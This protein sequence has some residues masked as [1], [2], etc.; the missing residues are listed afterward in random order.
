MKW[1][2]ASFVLFFAPSLSAVCSASW[3]VNTSTTIRLYDGPG[4]VGAGEFIVK[5]DQ[6][7]DKFKTERFRTFCVQLNEGVVLGKNLEIAG[8]SFQT[9]TSG[10]PLSARTSAL[11]RAFIDGYNSGVDKVSFFGEDYAK[12]FFNSNSN[13]SANLLQKAI[14]KYQGQG[15]YATTETVQSNKFVRAVEDLATD[16]GWASGLLAQDLKGKDFQ[17]YGGVRILN[18]LTTDKYGNKVQVQD[19]LYYDKNFSPFNPSPVPEPATIALLGLGVA[20]A[21]SLLRKRRPR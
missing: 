13:S 2:L 12:Y 6:V 17:L 14:W 9:M 11:Y 21:P 18:L 19:Q 7:G 16:L 1:L 20:F 5:T 8:I 15:N 10:Q 4:S 3:V